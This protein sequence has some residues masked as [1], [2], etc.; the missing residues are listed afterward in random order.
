MA[1][2]RDTLGQQPD[3]HVLAWF[4]A[5][6]RQHFFGFTNVDHAGTAAFHFGAAQLRSRAFE[7]RKDRPASGVRSPLIRPDAGSQH[8]IPRHPVAENAF[9][10][11]TELAGSP[12]DN[13][14]RQ[15]HHALRHVDSSTDPS[16][17]NDAIVLCRRI[18]VAQGYIATDPDFEV[19]TFGGHD[20]AEYCASPCRVE[21]FDRH[22]STTDGSAM[23]VLDRTTNEP[24]ARGRR[25]RLDAL[26][27]TRKRAVAFDSLRL[28][29]RS[30]IEGIM[31]S[32]T[33]FGELPLTR[34]P[35][36]DQESRDDQCQDC[37]Q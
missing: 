4:T 29:R 15:L 12:C 16:P 19:S 26:S 33:G 25:L 28:R 1:G 36:R 20:D 22:A 27:L 17:C 35:K 24:P 5:G 11:H 3:S 14:W 30:G 37:N 32:T 2:K 10:L 34:A 13:Q 21:L 18:D 23:L 8:D 31:P 7:Q 9:E 6:D